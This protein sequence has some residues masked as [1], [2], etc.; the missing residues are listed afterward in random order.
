M[1][2]LKKKTNYHKI[3]EAEKIEDVKEPIVVDKESV[4][5]NVNE[6]LPE[7]EKAPVMEP[8]RFTAKVTGCQN[9]NLRDKPDGKIITVLAANTTLTV[10]N[11]E[12]EWA[13]VTLTNNSGWVMKKYLEEV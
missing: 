10:E 4:C 13:K 3:R 6:S 7:I 1:N 12:N 9:L 11:V 2:E 5:E 8:A